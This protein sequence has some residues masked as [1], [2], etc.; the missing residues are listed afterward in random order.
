[1]HA[2]TGEPR[3]EA[4][5]VGGT[6]LL[7][8]L[9]KLLCVVDTG[10]RGR[11]CPGGSLRSRRSRSGRRFW[12]FTCGSPSTM[13]REILRNSANRFGGLRDEHV[14][15]RCCD[16]SFHRSLMRRQVGASV[17]TA[18]RKSIAVKYAQLGARLHVIVSQHELV[19]QVSASVHRVASVSFELRVVRELRN[20]APDGVRVAVTLERDRRPRRQDD[21]DVEEASARERTHVGVAEIFDGFASSQLRACCR[22]R[23]R[24]E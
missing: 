16:G 9:R 4:P 7:R 3:D 24:R 23:R 17:A 8:R 10:S 13:C 20:E 12:H 14:L 22:A 2:G 15:Q 11:R 5:L 1:M 21:G 18:A 6:L 19:L